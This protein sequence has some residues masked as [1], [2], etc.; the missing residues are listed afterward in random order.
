MSSRRSKTSNFAAQNNSEA[1]VRVAR[2]CTPRPRASQHGVR[3]AVRATP[4]D[5][6]LAWQKRRF[7]CPGKI[8]RPVARQ[9]HVHSTRQSGESKLEGCQTSSRR[10][11]AASTVRQGSARHRERSSFGSEWSFEDLSESLHRSLGLSRAC[12]FSGSHSFEWIL[13]ERPKETADALIKF[14]ETLNSLKA[15]SDL[16]L[17]GREL[18]AGSAANGW[19]SLRAGMPFIWWLAKHDTL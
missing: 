18:A 1:N 11:V 12:N 9:S 10:I 8:A 5:D 3:P 2:P 6:R 15:W 7:R 13:E 16:L 19:P 14:L 17:S 4:A